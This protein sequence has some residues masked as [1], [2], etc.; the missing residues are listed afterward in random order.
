MSLTPLRD[1]VIIERLEKELTTASG[2]ILKRNDDADKAKVIA[3]GSEV[4]D[5]AVGDVVLINWN[6]AK[7]IDKDT[8]QVN[9]NGVIAVF[10]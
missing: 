4:V 3:I 2:I 10:E 9:I 6:E 8:F 1:N 5:V 7:K